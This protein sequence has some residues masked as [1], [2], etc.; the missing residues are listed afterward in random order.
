MS[1]SEQDKKDGQETT[2]RMPIDEMLL[3]LHR[4]AQCLLIYQGRDRH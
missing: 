4:A 1:Q 2:Q 3:R